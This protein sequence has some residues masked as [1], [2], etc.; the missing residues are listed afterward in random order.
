MDMPGRSVTVSFQPNE[1]DCKLLAR[2][3]KRQRALAF[4]PAQ[5]SYGGAAW[6]IL[7]V[8]NSLPLLQ[9]VPRWEILVAWFLLTAIAY[10]FNSSALVRRSLSFES[11]IRSASV[12]MNGLG[13]ANADESEDEFYPPASIDIRNT[14]DGIFV[15]RGHSWIL[16][17]ARAF[18]SK[19]EQAIFEEIL[20][21]AKQSLNAVRI[22]PSQLDGYPWTVTFQQEKGDAVHAYYHGWGWSFLRSSEGRAALACCFLPLLMCAIIGGLLGAALSTGLLVGG[23]ISILFSVVTVLY[24]VSPAFPV[25]V[26]NK[27]HPMTQ[28]LTVG[29]GQ[30]G[31]AVNDGLSTLIIPWNEVRKIA[32]DRRLLS[33][34]TSRDLILIPRA[35]FLDAAQADEFLAAA[36]AYQRGETPAKNEAAAPWPPPVIH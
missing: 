8:V 29:L 9:S 2:R 6:L 36:Q 22:P 23:V 10:V 24:L 14:P 15:N 26:I 25:N 16:I 13:I 3:I 27:R 1:A 33:L 5:A 7:Q 34:D 28:P 32:S 18:E 12:S 19:E 35:T 4:L 31:V 11:M 21:H 30:D 17:P 20:L